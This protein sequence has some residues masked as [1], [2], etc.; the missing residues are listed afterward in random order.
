LSDTLPNDVNEKLRVRDDTRGAFKKNSM[1]NFGRSPSGELSPYYPAPS[2]FEVERRSGKTT[3]GSIV[4]FLHEATDSLE[5][6]GE[7]APRDSAVAWQL[8][9]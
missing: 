1:H 7:A 4:G 8:A 2:G 9:R 6:A 5:P 3:D